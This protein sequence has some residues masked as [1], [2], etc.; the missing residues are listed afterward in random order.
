[1]K[2]AKE[3]EIIATLQV[4]RLRR[5]FAYFAIFALGA[6]LIL[7]AFVKPPE[8]GWQVYLMLL[9]SGALIVA[10][11]LRR[12]TMLGLVLTEREL[13]DT[14]GHV[15]TELTNV[16]S[17]DRGAFAFKS[18]NGFV[19]RLHRSQP[20]AWAPGLWWRFSTRV[21]VGGVTESGPAKYMAEQ[22]ALRID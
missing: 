8:F 18:S 4:S 3:D 6:M 1:M 5:L 21:G 19:L 12:A 15:L 7:L 22:I 10:E 14:S 9:G 16:R 13:R 20:R 11:R 2:N 17:V